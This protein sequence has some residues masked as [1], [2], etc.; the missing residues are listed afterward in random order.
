MYLIVNTTKKLIN[1]SDLNVQIESHQMIDLDK[2]DLPIRIEDSKVLKEALKTGLLKEMSSSKA[3]NKEA[4][5]KTKIDKD[6]IYEN[7]K[8]L[9][10]EELS[11]KQSTNTV[12]QSQ[13]LSVLSELKDVVKNIKSSPNNTVQ[14]TENSDNYNEID[15]DKLIEIHSKTIS[16]LV[17]N[18]QGDIEYKKEQKED[19]NLNSSLEELE[20]LL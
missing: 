8:K 10:K 9:I 3:K 17:K 20:G 14:N 18:T 1:I 6:E 19:K 15:D 12:D 4:E 16:K 2:Y 11:N 5:N 13:L 7:I